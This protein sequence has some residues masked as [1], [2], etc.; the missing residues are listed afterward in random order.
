M[1][2]VP[3]TTEGLPAIRQLIAKGINV[4]TAPPQV[5]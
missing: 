4:N 1:I 3:A 2:K 5:Q